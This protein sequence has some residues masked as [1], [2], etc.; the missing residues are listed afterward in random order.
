M[1]CE[2]ESWSVRAVKR[3]GQQ[4]SW[5]TKTALHRQNKSSRLPYYDCKVFIS[6]P[7]SLYSFLDYRRHLFLTRRLLLQGVV[8]LGKWFEPRG[9]SHL[10]GVIVRMKVVAYAMSAIS[11]IFY[12]ISQLNT[13]LPIRGIRFRVSSTTSKIVRL[14]KGRVRLFLKLD[15][16]ANNNNRNNNNNNF[17]CT[18]GRNGFKYKTKVTEMNVQDAWNN[19]YVNRVKHPLHNY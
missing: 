8:E 7:L 1:R 17:I 9:I 3:S 16:I 12:F 15:K 13:S 4:T 18:F 19:W 10:F 11:L 5:V 14:K 6:L 2:V